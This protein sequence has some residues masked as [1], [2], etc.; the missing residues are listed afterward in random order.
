MHERARRAE[1]AA[2]ASR[3]MLERVGLPPDAADR[4]PASFSGGQRQRIAI[5]RALMLRPRLVICD[6]PVSALDLS[7]Q[8]QVLN[9]LRELQ[10]ELELSYLF[11]SHDLAVVRHVAHR[12]VVLYRGR[13]M[14]EGDARASTSGPRTRTRGRCSTP[15]RCRSRAAAPAPHGA[16]GARRRPH[17]RAR[18]AG[19]VSVRATLRARGRRLSRGAAAA[20]DAAGGDARRL[21]PLPRVAR[22]GA[23][24]RP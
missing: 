12:I 20:R 2:R 10:E 17:R 9:L 11:I 21:P 3:A 4:Y 23:L 13:V 24:D 8:A 19:V 18:V 1:L 6:E 16:G 5:A 22:A 14:E 15:R 7:V